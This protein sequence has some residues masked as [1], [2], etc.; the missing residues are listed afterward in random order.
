MTLPAIPYRLHTASLEH[1]QHAILHRFVLEALLRL[2]REGGFLRAGFLLE[3]PVLVK[4]E[5]DGIRHVL[6]DPLCDF[7]SIFGHRS[8]DSFLCARE[9]TEVPPV[10]GQIVTSPFQHLLFQ[11]IGCEKIHLS[12]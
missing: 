9:V 10:G 3:F 12:R 7:V 2:L 5:H 11:L 6:F 1:E 8:V 4:P